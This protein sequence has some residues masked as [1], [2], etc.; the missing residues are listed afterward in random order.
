MYRGALL[1]AIKKT[2]S[3]ANCNGVHIEKIGTKDETDQVPKPLP[4][5]SKNGFVNVTNNSKNVSCDDTKPPVAK[6]RATTNTFAF[7]SCSSPVTNSTAT[8]TTNKL[9]NYSVANFANFKVRFYLI[10]SLQ[11]V[12]YSKLGLITQNFNNFFFKT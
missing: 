7:N 9:T 6:P 1:D 2:D 11:N 12:F 3:F 10:I 4:R 8:N 5:L